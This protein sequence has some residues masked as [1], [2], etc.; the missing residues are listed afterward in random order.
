MKIELY[1]DSVGG[2]FLVPEGADLAVQM[3]VDGMTCPINTFAEDAR[4][5][6]RAEWDPESDSPDACYTEA[7]AMIDQAVLIATYDTDTDTVEI[8]YGQG[9]AGIR[10]GN[11]G[12]EYLGIS[13]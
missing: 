10:A 8:E 9:S 12:Q 6:A 1:E 3:I 4:G 13:Q 2:L 7:G 5:F 11:A